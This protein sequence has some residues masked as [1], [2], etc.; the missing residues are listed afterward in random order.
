MTSSVSAA[1]AGVGAAFAKAAPIAQSF[2]GF[3]SQL[4]EALGEVVGEVVGSG[5]QEENAEAI[6]DPGPSA[7]G[8]HALASLPSPLEAPVPLAPPQAVAATA[9]TAATAASPATPPPPQQPTPPLLAHSAQE[10][11]ASTVLEPDAAVMPKEEAPAPPQPPPQE[12]PVT[13]AASPQEMATPEMSVLDIGILAESVNSNNYT[14]P[15]QN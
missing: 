12:A 15:R 3:A 6:T 10:P 4:G 5:G 8:A 1:G 2:F 14:I 7:S 11:D 13:A 9:T